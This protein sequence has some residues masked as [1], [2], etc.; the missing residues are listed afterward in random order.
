[1]R[2]VPVPEDVLARD[3]FCACGCGERTTVATKTVVSANR[4]RGH[5]N[6]YVLGHGGRDNYGDRAALRRADVAASV[7]DVVEGRAPWRGQGGYLSVYV[8]N[9][10]HARTD[11]SY[12]QHRWVMEQTLGRF[13]DPAERVHHRNGQRD[14]NRPENLEL[15]RNPSPTGVRAADYHCPGCR[16]AR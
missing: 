5:P 9:H 8:P 3:G 6:L 4:Y 13:L 2:K 14:D 12:A 15:W 11:G 16:C 1:M 7:T 10:P